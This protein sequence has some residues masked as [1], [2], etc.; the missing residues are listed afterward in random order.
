MMEI[1]KLSKR[2]LQSKHQKQLV[3]DLSCYQQFSIKAIL[4]GITCF[5]LQHQPHKC[6]C[7][8]HTIRL[9]FS[10]F[11]I[12]HAALKCKRKDWLIG[13][14]ILCPSGA[15][16][17]SINCCFNKLALLKSIQACWSSIMRAPSHRND[18]ATHC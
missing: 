9:V 12:P 15:T 17:L 11:P 7:K 16:C 1:V 18:T 13:I 14:R 5:G 2:L 8:R 6:C 3:Q 10:G 4:I